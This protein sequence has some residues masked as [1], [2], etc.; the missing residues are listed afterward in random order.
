[1]HGKRIEV[2]SC[3]GDYGLRLSLYSYTE[4]GKGGGSKR[5]ET[6]S[7]CHWTAG[8]GMEE[9]TVVL[10]ARVVFSTGLVGS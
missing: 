4:G 5:K 8:A 10:Q 3:S 6:R 2:T 1:M 9:N 7:E